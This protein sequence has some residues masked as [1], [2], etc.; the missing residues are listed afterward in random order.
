MEEGIGKISSQFEGF[1]KKAGDLKE[2][3]ADIEVSI[4][5]IA[6]TK[7]FI[8]NLEKR[9]EILKENFNE[10]KG[11]EEDIKNRI[12]IIDEKTTALR[13]N[14]GRIE[15]V[16]ERFK[17]MD[18]LVTDI[19]ARTKQLQSTRE[20]LARTESRLTNLSAEA[21]R[22]SVSSGFVGRFIAWSL[23]PFCRAILN[24]KASRSDLYAFI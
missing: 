19:E 9:T 21:A 5:T 18:A 1:E 12:S 7:E 22:I 2:R 23:I 16:L 4:E 17:G 3:E 8:S 24:R 13:G 14:E 20:W 15:E 11:V 10:I 6:K